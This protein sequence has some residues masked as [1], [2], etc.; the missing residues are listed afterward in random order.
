VL[1]VCIGIRLGTHCMQARLVSGQPSTAVIVLGIV[2]HKP[3]VA[4]SA[5]R[6]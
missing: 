6:S 5:I 1:L 3:R 2:F 4:V